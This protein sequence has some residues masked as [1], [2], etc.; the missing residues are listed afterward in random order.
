MRFH[1]RRNALISGCLG[2]CLMLLSACTMTGQRADPPRITLSSIKIQDINLF[3]AV[4]HIEMRVVNPQNESYDIKG[5]DCVLD[6]DQVKLASGV[7]NTPTHIPSLDSAVIPL[8]IYS[9]VEDMAKCLKYLKGKDKINYNI[10]GKLYMAG[11]FL[12]PSMIAFNTEG[13]I[14]MQGFNDLKL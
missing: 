5:I 4:L 12:K 14:S 9:S 2:F 3:E 6:L 1:I 8:T 11:G 13:Q 7:S 10:K